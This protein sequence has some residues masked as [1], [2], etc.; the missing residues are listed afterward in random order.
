[1]SLSLMVG[2]RLYFSGAY[3]N[4][5]GF[6]ILT[7]AA[8]GG[9]GSVLTSTPLP[10]QG[11]QSSLSYYLGPFN[12]PGTISLKGTLQEYADGSY[13]TTVGA[14][15][16]RTSGV[17]ATVQAATSTPG[18]SAQPV[19]SVSG[20]QVSISWTPVSGTTEIQVLYSSGEISHTLTQGL[21]TP[22]S[23]NETAYDNQ[24]NVGLFTAD[25][26]ATE[27]FP[28][29]FTGGVRVRGTVGSGPS[30]LGGAWSPVATIVTAGPPQAN[31]VVQN[32]QAT[33]SQGSYGEVSLGNYTQY[34]VIHL[35]A[36]VYNNGNAVG[37]TEDLSAL[38]VGPDGR[39]WGVSGGLFPFV[40]V[41]VGGE[42][43]VTGTINMGGP[44]YGTPAPTGTF[45]V[46]VA[47][48]Q[49]YNDYAYDGATPQTT[50]VFF[51]GAAPGSVTTTVDVTFQATQA[52]LAIV[53]PLHVRPRGIQRQGV[54]GSR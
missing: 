29:G 28:A 41:P 48:S 23:D 27:A 36:T 4:A 53:R 21:H 38:I 7:I 54:R 32:L 44:F 39:V 12:T 49:A 52:T 45:T 15:Y 42:A 9:D 8:L 22:S 24:G 5:N 3:V 2:Q 20:D 34:P 51:G 19:V 26:S 16:T 25:T 14:A 50:R 47:P 1:M 31:L 17:I 13:T 37:T 46:Y 11:S 18:A 30:A 33:V 43:Q 40:S 6:W 10:G 35:S